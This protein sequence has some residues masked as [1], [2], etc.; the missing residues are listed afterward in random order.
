MKRKMRVI[1]FTLLLECL[2]LFCACSGEVSSEN[3]TPSAGTTAES[4]TVKSQEKDTIEESSEENELPE[5]ETAEN[6]S[7][8]S[9][10]EEDNLGETLVASSIE[11]DNLGE[12]PV[13]SSIEE[14]NLGETPV[15]SYTEESST[16]EASFI[17]SSDNQS[18]DDE[19]MNIPVLTAEDLRINLEREYAHI[20]TDV[21]LLG[22]N[23]GATI[24]IFTSVDDL[25]AD[26]ILF[27]YDEELLSVKES[28][29]FE[30]SGQTCFEY[31]VTGKNSGVSEIWIITTYDY[32]TLGEEANGYC[33]VV[34]KLDSKEGK[35]AYVTPT[36]D[37]YHLSSGCAGENATK[38]TY[39][40]VTAY[41]YEPCGK[42]AK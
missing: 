9:S 25:V 35:V 24:K 13:A 16:E 11:E 23:E 33:I 27:I 19:Q 18:E 5:S 28:E 29:P 22:N 21:I 37:K 8:A 39:Y 31:Y 12:T 4:D 40:D 32:L 34:K 14:D 2:I 20:D 26:D 30:E 7:V 1:L 6:S 3:Q 10:I 38:T 17:S 15:A 36:G 41:E 42:C